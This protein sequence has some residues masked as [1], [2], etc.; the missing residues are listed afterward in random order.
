MTGSL[1]EAL[2]AAKAEARRV[3]EADKE[4]KAPSTDFDAGRYDGLK[5]AIE[6]LDGMD[7]K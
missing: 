3:Y 6:I 2:E 1:R 5:Q 4:E 7:G